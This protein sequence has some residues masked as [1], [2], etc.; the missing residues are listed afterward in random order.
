MRHSTTSVVVA[1]SIAFAAG[2]AASAIASHFVSDAHA[3]AATMAPVMIDLAAL[4]H[5]DL[6][7]T[8]NPD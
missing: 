5:A 3:E 7:T 4:K 2:L 1:T 6:P 8:S